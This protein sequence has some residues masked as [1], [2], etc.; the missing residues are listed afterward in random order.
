MNSTRKIGKAG[1]GNKIHVVSVF[2][3]PSDGLVIESIY[4]GAQHFNG[5]GKGTLSRTA[6]F[7][8]TKVTCKRCLK[9]LKGRN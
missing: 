5:S 7:D 4:C 3:R 2:T 6:E 9:N 1:S 8:V